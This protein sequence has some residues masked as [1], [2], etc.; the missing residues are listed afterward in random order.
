MREMETTN[1]DRPDKPL[2]PEYA[3]DRD[4]EAWVGKLLIEI[5]NEFG[6]IEFVKNEETRRQATID[7]EVTTNAPRL[8]AETEAYLRHQV[9]GW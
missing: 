2:L 8:T 7:R 9:E 1:E 3:T 4:I 5:D 6:R